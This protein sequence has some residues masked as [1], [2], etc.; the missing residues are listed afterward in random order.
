MTILDQFGRPIK[1]E[2]MVQTTYN[3][4]PMFGLGGLANYMG[5]F[6]NP[7][8]IGIGTYQRMMDYDD[9]VNAAIWYATLGALVRIGEYSHPNKAIS[10]FI[11]DNFEY[12]NGSF[13]LA[14]EEMLSTGLS[15]GFSCAELCFEEIKGKL[16]L[17]DIQ[18]LNPYYLMFELWTEGP[19]KN[20]IKAVKQNGALL[21]SIDG[22]ALGV[23]PIEKFCVFTHAGRYGN[24]Y[25][26]ARLK[27]MYFPHYFKKNMLPAWGL[28]L[29]KFGTPQSVAKILDNGPSEVDVGGGTKVNVYDFMNTVFLNMVNGMGITLPKGID[30]VIQQATNT[31][32]SVFDLAV[33][34]A[35]MAIFRAGLLPGLVAS[36]NSSAG[37]SR[38]LGDTHFDIFNLGEDYLAKLIGDTAIDQII[39]KL[40]L[41]NFGP[42]EEWGTFQRKE[43]PPEVMKQMSDMFKTAFESGWMDVNNFN[44][45]HHARESTGLPEMSE[46]EFNKIKAEREAKAA[47]MKAQLEQKSTYTSNMQGQ[48]TEMRNRRLAEGDKTPSAEETALAKKVSDDKAA[49]GEKPANGQAIEK[50][51]P[52]KEKTKE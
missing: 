28:T 46:A 15:C 37:G 35:D 45:F 29:E 41:W 38:A 26:T 21:G 20:K 6:L 18:F 36:E 43:I 40:I 27:P 34:Y 39:R 10:D 12:E 31:G 14:M 52:K 1:K 2:S 32:V 47:E 4:G 42:Q 23:P 11:N 30:M 17:S 19:R 33:K 9:A 49:G 44:D 16:Y 7:D 48:L 25:G 5:Q 3:M 8:E 50:K 24:P 22:L 51:D 13:Y